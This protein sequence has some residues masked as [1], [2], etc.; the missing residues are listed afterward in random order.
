LLLEALWTQNL[1]TFSDVR[2]ADWLMFK[3]VNAIKVNISKTLRDVYFLS[4]KLCLREFCK[5]YCRAVCGGALFV[6]LFFMNVGQ[7]E[8]KPEEKLPSDVVKFVHDADICRYLSGEW[9]NSLPQKR[10]KELNN[11]IGETCKNI[12]E[13][14][15]CMENKYRTNK[16][17]LYKIKAY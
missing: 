5:K 11:E 8:A 16:N 17:I 3:Y 2:A 6:P 7:G 9:D 10:K 15:R 1:T 13:R 4:E 12:Y 14:Q